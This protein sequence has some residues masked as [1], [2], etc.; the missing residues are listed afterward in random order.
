MYFEHVAGKRRRY[1][2]VRKQIEKRHKAGRKLLFEDLPNYR[3]SCYVTNM[4]LPL[5]AIWNIYNARADC[6]N[7]I[8]EKTRLWIRKLL[9]QRFLGSGSFIWVYNGGL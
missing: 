8:K 4:D 3:Y 5:D 9:S 6:E 2:V 1:I 7:R